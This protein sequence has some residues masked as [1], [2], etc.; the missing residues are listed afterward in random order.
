VPEIGFPW[1]VIGFSELHHTGL[2]VT[3]LEWRHVS[4]RCL[5]PVRSRPGCRATI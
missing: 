4:S 3:I 5:L 2:P 1:F